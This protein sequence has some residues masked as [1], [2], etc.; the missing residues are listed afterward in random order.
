MQ[1][2]AY[3]DTKEFDCKDGTPVPEG[4][5]K[6]LEILCQNL[7]ILRK[8]IER[9]I[10]VISGYRTESHNQKVGGAKNSLHLTA[11]AAD[12]KVEGLTSHQLATIIEMLIEEKKMKEGGLGVYKSWVHYDVRDKKARW[13]K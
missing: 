4:Y 11:K 2:T 13:K 5:Y 12:I 8:T 9:P 7:E 6:Y 3:F 1:I 10:I